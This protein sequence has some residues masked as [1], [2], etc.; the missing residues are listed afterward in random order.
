MSK[1]TGYPYKTSEELGIYIEE[2][3]DC[4]FY[5]KKFFGLD[6]T[7]RVYPKGANERSPTHDLTAEQSDTVKEACKKILLTYQEPETQL[8]SPLQVLS[9]QQFARTGNV[10]PLPSRPISAYLYHIDQP[11]VFQ[12]PLF[13]PVNFSYTELFNIRKS[14]FKYP[15]YIRIHD[16]RP[17]PVLLEV[18]FPER[19]KQVSTRAIKNYVAPRLQ[20]WIEAGGNLEEENFWIDLWSEEAFAVYRNPYSDPH[21]QVQAINTWLKDYETEKGEKHHEHYFWRD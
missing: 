18:P 7:F 21:P 8:V 6:D 4:P 16:Q 9:L 12:E 15:R 14:D 5:F 20:D 13:N 17:H 2:E 10:T 1:D 19:F 3:T 11:Y